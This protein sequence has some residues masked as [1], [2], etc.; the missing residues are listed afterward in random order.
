MFCDAGLSSFNIFSR[1]FNLREVIYRAKSRRRGLEW[2]GLELEL[3]LEFTHSFQSQYLFI[4]SWCVQFF[5]NLQKHRS[6]RSVRRANSCGAEID[7][8]SSRTT[9]SSFSV[10]RPTLVTF[11]LFW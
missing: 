11:L 7:S 3:E 9:Q 10:G 4:V 8:P 2:I 6:F 5:S 1:M